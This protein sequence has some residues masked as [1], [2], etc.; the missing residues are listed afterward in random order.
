MNSKKAG[1]SVG[2]KASEARGL[3]LPVPDDVPDQ[4]F[5][6]SDSK[7][8]KY[9]PPPGEPY[10]LTIATHWEWLYVPPGHDGCD[11]AECEVVIGPPHP[12]RHREDNGGCQVRFTTNEKE[13]DG[14]QS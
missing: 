4:A 5:L 8:V 10:K 13:N 3:G 14:G 7:E 1:Y 12:T 2:M 6:V 11:V 9:P